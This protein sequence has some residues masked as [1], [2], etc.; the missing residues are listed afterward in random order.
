LQ[1]VKSIKQSCSIEPLLPLMKTFRQ[2]VNDCI[3]IGLENNAST[4]RKLSN[5]S[6]GRL[7]KYNIIAYYK[8]HAISKAAAI[9]A[10]RKQS[11]KRGYL[12]KTPYFK[13]GILISCYRFKIINGILKVP[14]GNRK[15]FDIPLN[16][17]TKE[18]LSDPSVTVRSFTLTANNTVSIF[19]S[20]EVEEIEC[21]GIEGVDR[22]L[23]NLTVG[24]YENVVQYDIS[25]AVDIAE[26]T[27]SI[28]RSF[29]R[30]DVRIR[31]KIAGKYGKRRRN[32]VNQLLHHVS[33][34]VVAR[35][36]EEKAG[37]AFEKL[38]YIRRL[39]QRGN[40]QSHSFRSRLNGWS[41]AEIKR[42]IEYKAAWEGVPIIQ[43]SVKETRGTSQLCPRCG[44]RLQ[45]DRLH[46]RELYCPYCDRW[47]DRDVVAA[48][49]IGRKGAEVFQRSQGLAG[50]AMKGNLERDPIILR[51]D[52]SKLSHR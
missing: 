34:Q 52:A 41:F 47:L 3:K 49:N 51:V 9:L 45:E 37:I 39:Y 16:K 46:R 40:G 5:L 43:L 19:Y 42:Q 21:T 6:Y 13:K 18:V 8:L 22:N 36:K 2:M 48:M 31:T 24:N 27:C 4:L 26:N 15:Y 10:N 11:I 17:Y 12:T 23:G 44:K 29:K 28:I 14:V 1:A 7:S 50:E 38:T 20:K 30:N 35:A 32:R 33:K 25:K